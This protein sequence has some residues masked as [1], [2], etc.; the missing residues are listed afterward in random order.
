[1][2]VFFKLSKKL[3]CAVSLLLAVLIIF[4]FSCS[5]L[6]FSQQKSN[7]HLY[8][9]AGQSNMAGRG[10]ITKIDTTA[11]PN[12]YVLN[13]ENKWELAVDPLHFD[14]PKIVGV[15]PGLSFGKTM[16][17]FKKGI[18]IGLIPCAVG[19]S[20]ISS[21]SEGGLHNQTKSYPYDGAL[22]RTEIAM[23]DGT[24]RGILWHQ[25]ESDS[26]PERLK[27]HQKKLIELIYKFRK[28]TKNPKLPFILGKLGDFYLLKNPHA[29]E[30][31]KILES[32]PKVTEHTSCIDVSGFTH[33]GDEIHFDSE[34]ARE[35][36]R[37]YANVMIKLEK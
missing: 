30:M 7:F 34:S 16:A 12:V 25:G 10:K 4:S 14:K 11:H 8:L 2:R 36:G 31:N 35:L 29:K 32:I 15:G 37:R 3:T 28:K 18:K 6:K 21:W 27:V 26:K 22:K 17:D 1:M 9:L 20:A 24:L 33:N 19:G 5:L 23:K 13:K